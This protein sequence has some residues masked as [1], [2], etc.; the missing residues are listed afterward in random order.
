MNKQRSVTAEQLYRN[1]ARLD[2]R[3]AGVR[4][5]A[6]RR[7]SGGDLLW[8]EI[9]FCME[10]DHKAWI[11]ERFQHLALPPIEVLDIPDDFECMDAELQTMLRSMLDPEINALLNTPR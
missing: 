2:V 6:N 8:A 5:D 10:P 4:S 1:D 9:V 3:S 7:V 11:A